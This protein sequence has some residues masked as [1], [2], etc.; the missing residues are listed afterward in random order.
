MKIGFCCK[1]M[2]VDSNN[3]ATNVEACNFKATTVKWL[4]DNPTKAEERLW[5]IVKHN[6]AAVGNLIEAVASM[7][8]RAR[9]VRIGSDMLPMYTHDDYQWFWSDS[10]VQQYVSTHLATAGQ[11]ARNAGIRLSMH[12]GQFT[13]LASE[14]DAIVANSVREFEYHVD[15]AKWMGYCAQF[16]DFKINVHLTGKGGVDK[17]RRTFASLSPEARSCITIE[18]DEYS[19]GLDTVLGIADLC[20][21]VLDIHHHL[22]NTGEYI[23]VDDPR[24]RQ[25]AD[26][27]RGVRPVIHYSQS[28]WMYLSKF[29]DVLPSYQDLLTVANRSQLRAHS[30]YYYHTKTND[31]ALTHLQWADVQSECKAKNLAAAE[32]IALVS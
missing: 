2:E 5:A 18:N 26:S 8:E 22:I 10:T 28:D 16:Q 27:W 3:R 6:V 14:S 15:I 25:V 12:P 7:P 20:P 4:R 19:S 30:R 13:V 9:M 21:I 11:V 32:L 29:A 1:L 31:W 23:A 24:I 17:F